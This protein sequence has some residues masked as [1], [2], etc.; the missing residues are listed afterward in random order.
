MLNAENC[1]FCRGGGAGRR[2][3]QD[4]C[5]FVTY[6]QGKLRPWSQHIVLFHGSSGASFHRTA[7]SK[8]RRLGWERWLNGS[9]SVWW[10]ETAPG[11]LC[12]ISEAAMKRNKNHYALNYL[13]THLKL[14]SEK[15]YLPSYWAIQR[16]WFARVNAL[17]NLLWK[18]SREVAVPFQANFWV[19]IASRSI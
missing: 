8:H 3:R 5:C 10:S 13:Q 4:R 16:S 9:N 15:T 1:L 2:H 6:L 11:Q 19:G 7:G 17:C 18:K 14:L 12:P